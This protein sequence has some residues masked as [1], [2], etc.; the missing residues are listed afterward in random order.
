MRKKRKK[1]KHKENTS[2]HDTDS[3]DEDKPKYRGWFFDYVE[4]KPEMITSD[5]EV[6]NGLK[7]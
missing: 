4:P 1:R 5:D 2:H 3:S 6:S 7:H